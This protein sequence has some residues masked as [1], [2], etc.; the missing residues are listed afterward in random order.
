MLRRIKE[1]N[2][3]QL[4]ARDGEIGRVKDLYFEDE[5]W[6]VRYLIVDTNK[7]LPG[8]QVLISPF[9]VR[10]IREEDRVV[11]LDLTQNQIKASPSI[12]AD[13][14][15][16]RRYEMQYYAYYNWP[17]YWNGPGLW[18]PAAYPRQGLRPIPEDQAYPM[19]EPKGDPH[20]R[21]TDATRGYH[22][23]ARDHE[24]GHVDDFVL[25]DESWVIRYLEV[26]TRNWWPGKHVLVATQWVSEVSWHES[27]VRVDLMRDAI[28]QAPAL[29]RATAISRDYEARLYAHYKRE[30][31][32][33]HRLA[34]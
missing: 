22:I 3:F 31:Y 34:A 10:N 2:G 7:W 8:R 24:I 32:W 28:Q 33:S 23:H 20:L 5:N 16:S 13:K 18:G 14:P 15:V 6:T 26:D 1:L 30:P 21:S 4:G 9:A 27:L 17:Y 12:D 19:G 25:D 29:D 11:D